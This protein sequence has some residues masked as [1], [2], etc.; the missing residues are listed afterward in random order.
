M[1]YNLNIFLFI[2][3]ILFTINGAFCLKSSYSFELSNSINGLMSYFNT[4]L[5]DTQYYEINV[6]EIK[7]YIITEITEAKN[8]EKEKKQNEIKAKENKLKE[9][10]V[11]LIKENIK[12]QLAIENENSKYVKYF[13]LIKE[14]NDAELNEFNSIN[15]MQFVESKLNVTE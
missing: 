10:L 6:A 8:L 11:N 9:Q 7:E 12:Q 1:M 5:Y 4:I 13:E 15:I 2:L 3:F 14:K